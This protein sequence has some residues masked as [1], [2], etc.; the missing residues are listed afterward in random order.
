MDDYGMIQMIIS[1]L[2]GIEVK[3]SNNMSK[4]LGC[5]NA[6]KQFLKQP[7]EDGEADG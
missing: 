4:L 7:E 1:T 5:I 3:G 6:L 2:E